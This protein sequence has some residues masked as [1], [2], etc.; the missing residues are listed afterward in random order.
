VRSSIVLVACALFLV[1]TLALGVAFGTEPIA[2][3]HLF[4]GPDSLERA[5][6]VDARLPRVLLGAITGCGL[7]VVGVAFQAVLPNPLAE[8]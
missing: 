8:P 1:A 5:A 3:S 7:A 2:L 6:L 4:D